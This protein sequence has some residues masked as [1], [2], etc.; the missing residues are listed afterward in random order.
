MCWWYAAGK[1]YSSYYYDYAIW[2]WRDPTESVIGQ[3][4]WGSG[5]PRKVS[6]LLPHYTQCCL[7]SL[8]AVERYVLICHPSRA[9]QILSRKKRVAGYSVLTLALL[10]LCAS[11]SF[12]YWRDAAELTVGYLLYHDY[13]PHN[14]FESVCR[15]SLIQLS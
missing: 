8:M 9:K 1:R 5:G 14:L 6:E 2:S 3:L 13:N 11:I 10:L 7:M 12:L 4:F 15:Q